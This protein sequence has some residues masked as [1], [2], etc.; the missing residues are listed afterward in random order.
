M[1]KYLIE[2]RIHRTPEV[3]LAH[4]DKKQDLLARSCALSEG[5]TLALR[6]VH[7]P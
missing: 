3:K 5:L 2:P 6:G 4:D 1:P 7:F